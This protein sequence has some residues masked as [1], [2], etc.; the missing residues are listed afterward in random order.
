MLQ[1]FRE[2][3][4]KTLFI[5]FFM[6][7]DLWIEHTACNMQYVTMCNRQYVLFKWKNPDYEK[8]GINRVVTGFWPKSCDN[9]E[10]KEIYLNG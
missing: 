10:H 5:P 8:H 3:S 1:D 4:V 7:E 9:P 6:I 2:N